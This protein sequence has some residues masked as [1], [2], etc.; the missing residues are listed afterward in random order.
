MVDITNIT[1]S[2]GKRAAR[3][4]PRRR[5]REE[6]GL[7]VSA[8]SE[9]EQTFHTVTVRTTMSFIHSGKGL[10][11]DGVGKGEEGRSCAELLY[12]NCPH[13][14]PATQWYHQHTAASSAVQ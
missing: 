14:H 12:P 3:Q 7:R 1:A 13:H 11:T 6:L 4:V 10:R 5:S 8:T 9:E 2:P